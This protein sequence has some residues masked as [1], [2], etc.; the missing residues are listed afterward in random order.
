MDD[1]DLI[2]NNIGNDKVKKIK[3]NTQDILTLTLHRLG[4]PSFLK[5]KFKIQ[6]VKK[7]HGNGAFIVSR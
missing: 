7:F 1:N 3:E 2:S 4:P 6:T 5:T